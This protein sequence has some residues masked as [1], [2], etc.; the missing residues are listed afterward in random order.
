MDGLLFILIVILLIIGG[1][2]LSL[3]L[4][5]H[6]ATWRSSRRLRPAMME[7][8]VSTDADLVDYGTSHYARKVLIFSVVVLGTVIAIIISL[9]SALI[10]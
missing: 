2:L 7:N 4:Y 8:M 9:I 5:A 6:G 3:R 10:H 1:T